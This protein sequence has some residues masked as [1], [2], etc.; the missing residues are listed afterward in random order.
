[1]AVGSYLAA[2]ATKSVRE[3]RSTFA[4]WEETRL[5]ERQAQ[6]TMTD[7]WVFRPLGRTQGD[8][9]RERKMEGEAASG[10]SSSS[11][12]S[13]SSS[14][15]RQQQSTSSSSSSAGAAGAAGSG[16]ARE[17]PPKP[18][19]AAAAKQPPYVNPDDYY[20][21]LGLQAMLQPRAVGSAA[22]V[23]VTTRDVQEGF[24]RELM[25]YHPDHQQD[26]GYDFN[27]C[28]ER[29]RLIIKA[30]GVLRDAHKRAAYDASYRPG[31]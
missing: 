21:V 25:R 22:T 26:D 23:G 16:R 9:A 20:A 14:Y 27:A 6:A 31:R 24:R 13:S 5:L 7:E 10:A 1:M 28:S 4:E 3:S 2:R 19:P 17:A 29:T 30:Y 12:S 11:R 8:R 15:T 18:R